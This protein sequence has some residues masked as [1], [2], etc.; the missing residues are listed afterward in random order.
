MTQHLALY[1]Q[2][3]VLAYAWMELRHRVA[4]AGRT[5]A[6]AAVIGRGMPVAGVLAGASP[7][8]LFL[9]IALL[10]GPIGGSL[11]VGLAFAS[12]AVLGGSVAI[13][14]VS[15]PP[16]AGVVLEL[17]AY[18]IL[19]GHGLSIPFAH[20]PSRGLLY[21]TAGAPVIT[22][23]WLFAFARVLRLT[24][25]LPGLFEGML[26]LLSYLFMGSLYLQHHDLQHLV[27]QQHGSST[28]YGLVLVFA[29]VT[30]GLWFYS[31]RLKEQAIGPAAATCWAMAAGVLSIV[32]TSKR[33][34]FISI[35]PP[36][37]VLMAP[38]FFFTY[39]IVSSYLVPKMREKRKGRIA[40]QWNVTPE[41][42]SS[43]LLLFCL[44]GNLV[45]LVGF[46]SGDPFLILGPAVFSGVL[47]WRLV[48]QTLR[49]A[50]TRDVPPE[51]AERVELLGIP[52]W[53]KGEALALERI[54]A[55]L[56]D[57]RKHML[58][59]PDSLALYRALTDEDYRKILLEADLCVPDGAGVVWAGDFLYEAPILQR[60]PGVE[61]VERLIQL[62][63]S[64]GYRVYFLGSSKAVIEKARDVMCA[65]YPGV[66]IVGVH[67]GFLSTPEIE[68]AVLA[69]INA[70]KPHI[71]FVGM[72]VP[73]QE[74]WI[75]EHLPRLETSLMMGVG[76]TFDVISGEKMRAPT[77]FQR[78]GLEWLY[79]AIRE[80]HRLNRIAYLPHFVIEVLR[81][82]LERGARGA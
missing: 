8:L 1:F 61:L 63:L 70:A 42:L 20:L 65:K 6:G 76:G 44:L 38:V 29:G 47:F 3:L 12:F 46:L 49:T 11:Q 2:G 35:V 56:G 71:I 37:L 45:A 59:T 41:R 30:T 7:Y 54:R 69:E 66:Q 13:A 51:A 43:L 82:K 72:G 19:V 74:K 36:A 5:V 64:D 52:I 60:M 81:D 79:R 17:V 26:A 67:D 77:I 75:A 31:Y 22:V 53:A 57:G 14:A 62:A 28:T 55:M 9:L 16:L 50:R 48:T 24:T 58:A 80:P 33:V 68:A 78:C 39:V 32:G 18:A 10:T 25:V 4:R 34:A 27:L 21:F 40:F 15:A 23:L 73:K